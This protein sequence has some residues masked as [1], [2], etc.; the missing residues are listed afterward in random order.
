MRFENT[1]VDVDVIAPRAGF[2][3][4]NSVWHPWWRATVDGKD[5]R[6]MKANVLF[7]A[8]QVPQGFHRVHFEF[9][10][11]TGALAEATARLESRNPRQ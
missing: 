2:L 1:V 10:A 8:V 9:D 5:A 6:I 11:I 4:F 7:R 3:V